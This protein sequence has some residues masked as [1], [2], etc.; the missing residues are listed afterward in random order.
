[1]PDR[2]DPA[3]TSGL[4]GAFDLSA[5]DGPVDR[6]ASRAF[7]DSD[8]PAVVRLGQRIM[9]RH[10]RLRLFAIIGVFAFLAGPAMY[11][12]LLSNGIHRQEFARPEAVLVV[13][14]FALTFGGLLSIVLY[15]IEPRRANG[16]HEYRIARF[17]EAN[18]FAFSPLKESAGHDGMLFANGT[19]HQRWMIVRADLA[20]RP[21]EFG[22]L[23]SRYA[24][25][26]GTRH[27][28]GYIAMRL[29]A[30]LPRMI[31]VKRENPYLPLTIPRYPHADDLVDV[32]QGRAFR[33][34]APAGAAFVARVLFTPDLVALFS[35]LAKRY[36]IEITGDT[37]FLTRL[38]PI[39]T[40]SARQWRRQLA[41][42][43]A[44]ARS[45]GASS[46]WQVM[47]SQPKRFLPRLPEI[48]LQRPVWTSPMFV[49]LVVGG[50]LGI[51]ALISLL[52]LLPRMLS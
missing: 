6:R 20:G 15:A 52:A 36:T 26:S 19:G 32:G 46:V 18:G 41:D 23:F 40:A 24:D 2:I 13:L 9:G 45:V 17:A 35:G 22:N 31:I 10:R 29:P 14:E 21:V 5:F 48:R 37:L 42:V 3:A 30:G 49:W 39:S 51:S 33:L 16:K 38:R 27:R 11:W 1:M 25:R 44:L 50:I 12:Y 8:D 34:Y 4:A 28:R 7:F 47:R 43:E